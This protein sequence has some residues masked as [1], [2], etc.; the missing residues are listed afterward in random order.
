MKIYEKYKKAIKD[1]GTLEK[2]YFTTFNL[3]I[4]FVERYILPP[5]LNESRIKS[6]KNVLQNKEDLNYKLYKKRKDIKI[7][8]DASMLSGDRK[9]TV[10]DIRSVKQKNGV[11]HPKVIYLEGSDKSFLIVGSGNLTVNG[12]GRNIEAFDIVE[13]KT[14]N[15]KNQVLNFFD[16]LFE[17]SGL[18]RENKRLR[19]TTSE[20]INFVYSY[21]K[22]NANFLYALHLEKNLQIYSPYFS[23]LD[24]LFDNNEFK[25]LENI[26]IV[27]DLI[28]N[29]KIRLEK[30]PIDKKNKIK[31]YRFNKE[32]EEFEHQEDSLNH[33]KVWISDTHIAI[34][35]YNCTREALFGT[36]FE[37][38]LVRTYQDIEEL[39]VDS[40]FKDI[41]FAS[42]EEIDFLEDEVDDKKRFTR[43]F[44][45]T[46]DY[47]EQTLKLHEIRYEDGKIE[48]ELPKPS[49]RIELKLPTYNKHISYKTFS[50]F[51]KSEF[52]PIINQLVND[53]RFEVY[54]DDKLIYR[55]FIDEINVD[56]KNRFPVGANS[57]EEL[58]YL[59]DTKNPTI[60]KKLSNKIIS[61]NSDRQLY[62][63]QKLKPKD[64][65]FEMFNHFK[66]L[67]EKYDEIKDNKKQMEIFCFKSISS[68]SKL[69]QLLEMEK[70]N[71]RLYIYLAIEEFNSLVRKQKIKGI[72]EIENIKIK[73]TKKDKD[74]I[75]K[76]KWN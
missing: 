60:S 32:R 12:W 1:I 70:N 58:F 25:T 13:I 47:D 2:A 22:D 15:L 20:N 31:F 9:Q 23:P 16:D 65:Y 18:K 6:D 76:I 26:K 35:S 51:S 21:D 42:K 40:E 41:E 7:F 38:A 59:A 69:R 61:Y 39:Q 53:K 28:L 5:L 68:L 71:E 75:G 43:V 46:A 45:L 8:Y 4:D 24:E 17:K 3:D 44:E 55:G 66:N 54:N 37:A 34:G 64:N 56:E 48:K 29:Q 19:P 14:T 27:P 62:K 63:K 50:N 11:F 10:V 57:L 33:S 74:F 52:I 72:K 49:S 30:K 67:R 73:L 36:N